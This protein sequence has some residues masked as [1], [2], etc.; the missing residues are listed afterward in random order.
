MHQM[1]ETTH[2]VKLQCLGRGEVKRILNRGCQWGEVSLIIAG[3]FHYWC[4]VPRF[5]LH[6]GFLVF[7]LSENYYISVH[8]KCIT[9]EDFFQG[10]HKRIWLMMSLSQA[11]AD[12]TVEGFYTKGPR[13]KNSFFWEWRRET[14]FCQRCPSSA[15]SSSWFKDLESPLI[16]THDEITLHPFP[17]PWNLFLGKSVFIHCATPVPVVL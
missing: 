5:C 12:Q 9:E 11:Q 4:I 8:T 16:F 2:L 17:K 6:L 13:V 10:N 1:S 3:L 7:I 14:H 15:Q